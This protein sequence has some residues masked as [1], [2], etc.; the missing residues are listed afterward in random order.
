MTW[1]PGSHPGEGEASG[2]EAAPE[3]ETPS[4]G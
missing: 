2:T 4:P 3:S 1:L